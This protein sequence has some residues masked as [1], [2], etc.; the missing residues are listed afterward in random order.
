MTFNVIFVFQEWL[1]NC[2]TIP[3]HL[4]K[5]VIRC[6]IIIWTSLKKPEGIVIANHD[7]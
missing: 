4:T 6:A 2:L 7:R 1:V 3:D 5:P